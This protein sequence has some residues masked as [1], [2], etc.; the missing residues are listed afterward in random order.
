VSEPDDNADHTLYLDMLIARY[1]KVVHEVK[2]LEAQRDRLAELILAESDMPTGAKRSGVVVMRQRRFS[3]TRARERLTTEDYEAICERVPSAK[4]AEK[5]LEPELFDELKVAS[6]K[7][8][9][10]L[11]E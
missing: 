8:F 3:A 7:R 11:A 9:L 5:V 2:A 10:R 1:V 6:G 4:L